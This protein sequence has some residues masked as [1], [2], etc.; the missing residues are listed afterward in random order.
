LIS[1]I[2][3]ELSTSS[4]MTILAIQFSTEICI[5]KTLLRKNT[6]NLVPGN[7]ARNERG[8]TN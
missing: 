2:V 3:S 7:K 1:A 6:S 8:K 4:L 5:M